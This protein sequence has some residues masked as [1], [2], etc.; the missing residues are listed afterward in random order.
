MQFLAFIIAIRKNEYF[1]CN[2]GTKLDRIG[3]FSEQSFDFENL[4]FL[5]WFDLILTFA[6]VKH[7]NECHHRILRPKRPIVKTSV[8]RQSCNIF[9]WWP[10]LDLDVYLLYL[11][12]ILIMG[13]DMGSLVAK[14]VV[15]TSWQRYL[16]CNDVVTTSL[17]RCV[18]LGIASKRF[19]TLTGRNIEKMIPGGVIAKASSLLIKKTDFHFSHTLW[20]ILS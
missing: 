13:S 15:M 3:M 8:A 9:I 4:T 1:F 6:R 20:P 5:T 12:P 19:W 16:R 7:R 10:D 14:N 11:R 2:P 18:L 17:R